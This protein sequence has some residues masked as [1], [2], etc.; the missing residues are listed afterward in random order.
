MAKPAGTTNEASTALSSLAILSD[1][2]L[3][4]RPGK[5]GSNVSSLAKVSRQ[6]LAAL[7][8]SLLT[9]KVAGTV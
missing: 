2:E 7:V 8:T 9:L 3:R 5:T 6:Q 4:R 1:L